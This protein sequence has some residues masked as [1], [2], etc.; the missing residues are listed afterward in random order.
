MYCRFDFRCS[1]GIPFLISGPSVEDSISQQKDVQCAVEGAAVVIFL[2]LL[3]GEASTDRQYPSSHPQFLIKDY[4]ELSRFTLRKDSDKKMFHLEISAAAVTD[5]ALYYCAVEP[6]VTG[7]TDSLHS[8]PEILKIKG[9]LY[10]HGNMF[11]Y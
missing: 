2:P 8:P 11:T 5:S 7:N 6:T 1:D 3:N 10:S 9:N 4:M